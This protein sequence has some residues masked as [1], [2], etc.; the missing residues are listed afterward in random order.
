MR[1]Y[2]CRDTFSE[3]P[4]SERANP[5]RERNRLVATV[6]G[7][8][9]V[10]YDFTKMRRWRLL[11][12]LLLVVAL[13]ALVLR[14]FS[15]ERTQEKREA[16]YQSAVRSYSEV[17]RL[18]MTRKE[19]EDYLRGRNVEF[20]QMCCVETNKRFST[21]VYDDLT[22]IGQ[23]DAPW[24]CSEKNVYVAFQFTGPQRNASGPTAD[25][26]DRLVGVTL[27]RGLEG[28]L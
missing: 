16:G 8:R 28:C 20:R 25:A 26:S 22:K 13:S 6:I 2:S 9:P 24:V 12:A 4:K 5:G 15:Q 27:Y 7:F 10:V 17:L 11:V 3:F 21:N 14:H 18:G 19:V 23:E 1:H